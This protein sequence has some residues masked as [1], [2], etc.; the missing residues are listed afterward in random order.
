MPGTPG[1]EWAPGARAYTF[2]ISV[3]RPCAVAVVEHRVVRVEPAILWVARPGFDAPMYA[4]DAYG[5]AGEAWGAGMAR[6]RHLGDMYACL[7]A[8]MRDELAAGRLA[9]ASVLDLEA[10]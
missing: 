3:A 10:Y 9:E 8:W 7:A 2:E 6:L 5:T 1:T 4:A